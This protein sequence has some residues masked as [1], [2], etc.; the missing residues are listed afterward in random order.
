MP[1]MLPY[2]SQLKVSN[3]RNL[4]TQELE[5]DPG[6]NIMFGDNGSGKT[7]LLEAIHLLSLGRSFRT[8]N[9][10][11]FISFGGSNC[12]VRALIHSGLSHECPQT[13][14]G[15]EKP[16]SGRVQ[17]RIGERTESS[18]SAFTRILPVQLIDSNSYLLV[19]GGPEHRRQFIDWGVFHVEHSF[20]RSWQMMQ[21]ALDQRNAALRSRSVGTDVWADTFAQHAVT[22]DA[23]RVKYISEFSEIFLRLL[24]EIMGWKGIEL[25]YKRGWSEDLDLREALRSGLMQ[26]LVQ[27]YT[28]Y[29]PQRADLKFLVNGQPV[30]AV[31][32]RGQIKMFV[33][34]MLLARAYY[35]QRVQRCVFLLDELL[36]ELDQDNSSRLVRALVDLGGQVFVTGTEKVRLSELLAGQC[37]KMFHV[38]H[39]CVRG[40]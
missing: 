35:L 2:I 38:E 33:C 30:K 13:W 5:F 14:L 8:H 31:F 37:G 19:E 3:I 36:A 11:K 23:M 6:F 20:L 12:I 7:S 24:D 15:I 22:V 16:L 9:A 39:G 17:L 4:A 27:G 21:R 1:N 10:S 26:D 34:I 32:S 28:G 18:I 25:L 29:G 40:V